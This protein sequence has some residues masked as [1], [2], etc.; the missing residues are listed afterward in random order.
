MRRRDFIIL[1]GDAVASF[2]FAAHAQE[3]GQIYRLAFMT[4]APRAAS[5]NLAFFDELRCSASLRGKT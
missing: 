5:R 2:P 1:M 4:G 3:S